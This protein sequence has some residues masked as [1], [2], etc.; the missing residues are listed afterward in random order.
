MSNAFSL[1][2]DI[3]GI[4]GAIFALFAWLQT[5]QLKKIQ[6][7]EQARQNKHIQ[8][9]LQSSGSEK[10]E[11]PVDIRRA[12][13]T[14]SE[15]LGR[16]GMVPRKSKYRAGFSIEY[17]NSVEFYKQ[18]TQ[19]ATGQGKGLITVPLSE[20]EFNQFNLGTE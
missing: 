9:V 7:R 13:L 2:A 20:D 15:I 17:L 19:V 4:L 6:E 10:I 8:I 16:I 14:R 5:C 12:E 18:L 1:I 3:I 11:L